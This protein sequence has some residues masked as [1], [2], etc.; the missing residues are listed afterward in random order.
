MSRQNRDIFIYHI[1]LVSEE[2]YL[3]ANYLTQ[4]KV[5]QT[6]CSQTEQ[7]IVQPLLAKQFLNDC[8]VHKSIVYSVYTTG[9]L[10]TDLAASLLVI[11]LDCLAHYIRSLRGCR[12]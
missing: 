5:G 6:A 3:L 10:E 8:I 9:R 7:L 2:F 4:A 1:Y 11:L 12:R